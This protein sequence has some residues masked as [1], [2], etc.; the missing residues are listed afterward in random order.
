VLLLVQAILA[1]L[2]EVIL[3]IDIARNYYM[4]YT[5][6]RSDLATSSR[7]YDASNWRYI[8]GLPPDFMSGDDTDQRKS[9]F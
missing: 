7:P 6:R 2:F 1:L 8:L 5:N 4:E 9:M 3:N